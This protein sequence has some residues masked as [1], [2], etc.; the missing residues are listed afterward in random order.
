MTDIS[1]STDTPKTD[2]EPL[3]ETYQNDVSLRSRDIANLIHPYT[4]LKKHAEEG[5]FIITHGHG[6][7]V[8]DD[9]GQKY[10]EAMSGLW[11][12]SLGFSEQRLIDAAQRQMQELPFYHNFSGK[13]H[14][15]SIELAEKLLE[16]APNT[17]A[18]AFFC[19]SGS[20]A[21]DTAIKMIWYMNNALNRPEKKKIIA[22]KNAYHGVTIATAS[23]TGLPLNHNDFDLPIQNILHTEC[24]HYYRF[25][26][27]GDTEEQF[28]DRLA[29]SLE[30]LIQSEGP[31]TIAA[32]IAEP[33]MGAGGVIV[34]PHTYFPKIQAIL[35]KYDI[36]IIADEVIC[37]F[38]RTGNYWG[39]QT[40]GL[41]PDILTCAKALSSAYMPISAVM[42]SQTIYDIISENAHRHGAFG[43]G[44][45]YSA[46]PVAASVALETLKIYEERDIVNRVKTLSPR[47][48]DGLRRFIDHPLVGDVRGIG[49]L[50]ALELAQNPVT[51]EA[52]D[53][54]KGVGA[55]F[56]KR[57]QDH[58]MIVRALIGDVIAY[59]PPLIVRDGDIINMMDITEKALDETYHWV[60]SG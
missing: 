55:Y 53:P 29:H 7:Y 28:A 11:C 14:I 21:N 10:I 51:G 50:G 19:N 46:H 18:R 9:Q 37:G 25:A 41:Q 47:L 36:L 54:K 27:M 6:V 60:K 34:P 31:E 15:A 39:S 1:V 22:R 49:L 4:N 45:T 56:V 13:G 38:G 3:S 42:V 12:T 2:I 16:V 58:G 57:A 40:Y 59:C 48:Q 20:E 23:L 24:P 33:V 5:P 32:F 35:K 44:Y 30:T 26:D 8:Y 52:F 43:H 17:M